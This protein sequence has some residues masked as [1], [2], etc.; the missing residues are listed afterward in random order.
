[1]KNSKR[2]D[3]IIKC[4]AVV[5]AL[6]LLAAIYFNHIRTVS[7]IHYTCNARFEAEAHTIA[8]IIADYL[9]DSSRSQI[10]SIDELVKT[11]GYVPLGNGRTQN[12][13]K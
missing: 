8:A 6:G 13:N 7:N 2:F 3:F 5:I 4:I 10:P 1:M 12:G 11:G 9:S